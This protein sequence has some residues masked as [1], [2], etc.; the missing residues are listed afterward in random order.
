MS[1][2]NSTYSEEINVNLKLSVKNCR[3]DFGL[4]CMLKMIHSVATFL[5]GQRKSWSC[6]LL[7]R[8]EVEARLRKGVEQHGEGIEN[9]EDNGCSS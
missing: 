3:S 7:N 6:E 1:K 2:N 9:K 5:D 4:V 8:N